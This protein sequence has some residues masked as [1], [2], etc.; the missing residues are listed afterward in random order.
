MWPPFELPRDGESKTDSAR[1]DVLPVSMVTSERKGGHLVHGLLS[2]LRASGATGNAKILHVR[3]GVL[4]VSCS[5]ESSYVL[6]LS[7]AHHKR[8]ESKEYNSGPFVPHAGA[9]F[10][11]PRLVFLHCSKV[12]SDHI[13]PCHNVRRQNR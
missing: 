1:S 12:P 9:G 2:T 13:V 11:T 6:C 8:G 10:G 7:E 3:V 5:Q 4:E